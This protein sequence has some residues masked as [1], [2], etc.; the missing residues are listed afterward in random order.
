[1][2]YKNF[3]EKF[4]DNIKE[5]FIPIKNYFERNNNEFLSSCQFFPKYNIILYKNVLSTHYY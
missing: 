1:M 5:I 3:L 2:F 4:K